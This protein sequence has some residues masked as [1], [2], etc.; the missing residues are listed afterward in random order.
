[1][2]LTPAGRGTQSRPVLIDEDDSGASDRAGR[3]PESRATSVKRSRS[4]EASSEDEGRRKR[5]RSSPPGEDEEGEDEDDDEDDDDGDDRGKGKGR[6]D[7]SDAG[8][9]APD[10]GSPSTAPQEQDDEGASGPDGAGPSSAAPGAPRRKGTAWDANEEELAI[11]IMAEILYNDDPKGDARWGFISDT[12][13]AE[14]DISRSAAAVKNQ[15]NRVLRHRS[16]LDERIR[17]S[18]ASGPRPLRTG[19]LK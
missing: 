3:G 9:G 14:H 16:G 2:A 15:W 10:A 12:L 6:D 17:K 4:P 1:M 13:R 7:Q 8:D 18:S 11:A 5:R 19:L